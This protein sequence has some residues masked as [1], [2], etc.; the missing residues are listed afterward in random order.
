M[1]VTLSYL[2]CLVGSAALAGAMLTVLSQSP[3]PGQIIL[4]G[5]L[6]TL[7]VTSVIWAPKVRFWEPT[8]MV[9]LERAEIAAIIAVVTFIICL[10]GLAIGKKF[11][12]HLAGKAG[13]MGGVILIVIGLEIFISS[14]F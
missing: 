6:A 5:V 10:G 11:G 14:W 7:A 4:T 8:R 9:W 2:L 12:T 3:H 13:I 1:G